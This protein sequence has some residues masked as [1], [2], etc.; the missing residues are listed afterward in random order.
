MYGPVV[1]GMKMPSMYIA[2]RPFAQ[3][4]A[5]RQ[6]RGSGRSGLMLPP[7]RDPLMSRFGVNVA[8]SSS[9]SRPLQLHRFGGEGGD[10]DRRVLQR[11]LAALGRDDDLFELR[12]CCATLAC[13]LPTNDCQR[14]PLLSGCD[15]QL[16]S[17]Y[18][19]PLFL[20]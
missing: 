7:P 15:D 3:P 1:R 16:S 18:S 11:R 17:S 2:D 9:V 20:D 6:A 19:P 4:A 14:S 13:E 8:M 10:G 12:V 5:A